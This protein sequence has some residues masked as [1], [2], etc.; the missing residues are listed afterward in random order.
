MNRI[1]I[2]LFIFIFLNTYSQISFGKEGTFAN[3]WHEGK[4]VLKNKDT[5]KGLKLLKIE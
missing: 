3:K 4:L 1:L 5:L 2:C